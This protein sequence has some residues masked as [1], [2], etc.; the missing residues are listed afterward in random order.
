MCLLASRNK[1]FLLLP[2]DLDNRRSLLSDLMLNGICRLLSVWSLYFL[3]GVLC[4]TN[5]DVD[6][7]LLALV[8]LVKLMLKFV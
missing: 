1:E 8:T 6:E 2:I 5:D 7:I 4:M 3:G